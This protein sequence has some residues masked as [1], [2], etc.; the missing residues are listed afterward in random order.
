MGVR[1]MLRE[2]V[3]LPLAQSWYR[4]TGQAELAEVI[5]QER[6]DNEHLRESVSDLQNRLQDPSWR[7]MVSL[8][9]QEFTRDGLRQMTAVC[10]IMALKNPLIR[11]GLGLRVAY[12]W[13]QGVNVTARDD[14]VND[15]VQKFLAD[16]SNRRTLTGA[17]AHETLERSLGTDGNVFLACFTRPT[18]GRVQVRRLPWDEISDIITSPDDSSEP[19]FYRRD[20]WADRIDP[21]LGARITE[22]KTTFYPALGYRPASRPKILRD[23]DGAV[24]EILWDA[25]VYHVKVGGHD[26]WKF[27]IPDSY[28]ALDWANAYREFLTDWARLVKSLSR[29]AWRLTSPGSKQAA[30]KVRLAAGGGADRYGESQHAGATAVMTSDMALEAVPKSGA[31]IDS[32]SGRPLAAMAASAL[33]IP[34][35]MLLSD[36]GVTGARATAETLDT[37]T[38]RTM[39]LRRGVWTEAMQAILDHVILSAV[40][41]TEPA[42]AGKITA[43]SYDNRETVELAGDLD[44]TVDISWPDID[45]L[46]VTALIDAIVKADGTTH[47]P[48]LL[49]LRMILEAFKIKDLDS[50]LARVTDENGNFV[51]PAGTQ[52]QTAADKFSRGE[53]PVAAFGSE[54]SPATL[55]PA[56][57][58]AEPDLVGAPA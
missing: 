44:Q 52:G 37:P 33:D 1:E 7:R 46:D 17:Q 56:D 50:I 20:Y 51:P 45:N 21:I 13:G 35:T 10:R 6:A 41:A 28:A 42:L 27:G 23:T 26:G 30:A 11:R 40:R 29:F 16:P 48:P 49:I 36:P 58:P 31:T 32:E 5:R 54:P 15:I 34:V 12:V 43:D 55:P 53:D 22:R 57:E 25:P 4:V 2:T 47:V 39:E 9:E 19:R 18:T 14:A 38:E 8:A 24:G 3:G